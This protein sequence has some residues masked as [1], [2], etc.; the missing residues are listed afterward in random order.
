ME[1]TIDVHSTRRSR[2]GGDVILLTETYA[3][4]RTNCIELS[5]E[6]AIDLMADL[7]DEIAEIRRGRIIDGIAWCRDCGRRRA[8][9]G[10]DPLL[11]E[12]CRPD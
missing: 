4:C 2:A 1:H 8:L 5:I 9:P 7:T 10:S 12:D 3:G 6:Q 11:C